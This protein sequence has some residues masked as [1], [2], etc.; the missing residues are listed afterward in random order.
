MS[1]V[2][3]AL[4]GLNKQ[5]G[6]FHHELLG[7]WLASKFREKDDDGLYCSEC[8]QDWSADHKEWCPIGQIIALAIKA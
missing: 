6:V 5:G 1:D 7:E 3:E 8:E 4:P 2:A